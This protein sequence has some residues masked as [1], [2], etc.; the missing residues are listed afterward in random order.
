L[1][2]L[3]ED[4]RIPDHFAVD[5]GCHTEE[6]LAR[7]ACGVREKV[8]LL[9]GAMYTFET[10]QQVYIKIDVYIGRGTHAVNFRSVAGGNDAAFRK[11]FFQQSQEGRNLR[12]AEK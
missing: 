8:I 6:L 3:P 5:T 1:A 9:H 10:E 12:L 4:L 2:E 7:H 11:R